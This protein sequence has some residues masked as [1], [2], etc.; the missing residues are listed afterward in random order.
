MRLRRLTRTARLLGSTAR[1]RL[2]RGPRQP[3][4]TWTQELVL[5]Y[6]RDAFRRAGDPRR[7]RAR[8]DAIAARRLPL[9]GS[10]WIDTALDGVPAAHITPEGARPDRVLLYLHGGGYVFGSPTSHGVL[11]TRLAEHMRRDAWSL[12]YRLAPEHPCPAAIDD[13]LTA[14]RALLDD[15]VDPAAV[16]LA[17]DSAGG[18]LA[19]AALMAM[20]DA[21][22]PRPGRAVLLSP[23][24]DLT[25]SGADMERYADICYLGTRDR[26]RTFAA[27]YAGDL[28][29]R[30][31]RVSPLF[32]DLSDLPPLLV[33]VGGAEL[34]RDDGERLAARARDAG[35]DVTLHV[36]PGEV[37]VYPMFAD[38]T[39][40][41][42]RALE[43]FAAWTGDNSDPDQPGGEP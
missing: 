27:H 30:D 12:H 6:L 31:P 3:H 38:L 34:I 9:R 19:L 22:L 14:W 40:A 15:G 7:A 37:H 5:A 20:R 2:R 21:G 25:V 43:R 35:T 8:M 17:G 33:D 39:P 28:D 13:V 29:R 18:G 41:G 32:G 4:W 23:W 36:E 10:T 26:L 16:V 1:E 11:V 42:L 24:T